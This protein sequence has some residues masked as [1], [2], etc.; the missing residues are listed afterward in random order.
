M[1][2]ILKHANIC[3]VNPQQNLAILKQVEYKKENEINGGMKRF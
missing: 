2:N 1:T 3:V